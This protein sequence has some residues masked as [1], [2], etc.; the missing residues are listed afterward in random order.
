MSGFFLKF[1]RRLNLI[2]LIRALMT[3]LAAAFILGGVWLILSKLIMIGFEPITSLFIGLGAFLIVTLF[4]FIIGGKSDKRFAEE[5]DRIFGLKARVQTM[6][7]YRNE[8][9]D[10]VSMQRDD[11]DNALSEIKPSQY[12]FKGLWIHIAALAVSVAVIA[13]ALFA[14]KDQRN[15]VPPEEKIPFSLSA[16]QESGLKALINHIETSDMEEEFRTPMA[17]RVHQLLDDLREVETEDEMIILVN[18]CMD[19]VCSIT[20]ESSTS[21][22]MLNALWS[23]GD[24]NFKHLAVVLD[25]SSI[26]SAE[27]ADFAE[28]FKD[29]KLIL[30]GA[31]GE[32]DQGSKEELKFA[33]DTM[34]RKITRILEA[35]ALSEDDELYAAVNNLFVRVPG[36][37]NGLVNTIDWMNEEEARNYL[38]NCFNESGFE[39]YNAVMLNKKNADEGEYTMTRLASLFNVAIP[40]FERPDFVKNGETI[41]SEGDSDGKDDNNENAGS[42]GGIGEGAQYGSDDIVLDPLTGEYKKYGDLIAEYNR[43][44]LEKLESDLYTEEQKEAIKKYFAMLYSGIEKKEGQ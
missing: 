32:E 21:T 18:S 15:V 1:K 37:L 28:R 31:D 11:T 16:L 25:T 2:R 27:W 5:L 19:D 22:E 7:A 35:S 29:Y 3:G 17:D 30:L 38:D 33:I 13:V 14:V 36:G 26:T 10:M 23:N 20:R 39:L 40:E 9:G 8:N 24:D 6:I 12:K 42:G 43:K 34:S 41:G 4:V 44:M